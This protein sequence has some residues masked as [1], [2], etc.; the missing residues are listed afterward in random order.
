MEAMLGALPTA[1]GASL[2]APGFWTAEPMAESKGF[3]RDLGVFADPKEANAPEPRPKA[4]EAPL[5]GDVTPPPA[6]GVVALKGPVLMCEGV[7]PLW[8]FEEALREEDSA[9]PLGPVPEV[10]RESFPELQE[11]G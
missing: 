2:D 9:E 11:R 1:L 8:R 6:P 7:S 4:L 5:V 3:P 10:E